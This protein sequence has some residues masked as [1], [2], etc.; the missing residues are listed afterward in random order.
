LRFQAISFLSGKKIYMPTTIT[1]HGAT[2]LIQSNDLALWIPPIESAPFSTEEEEK[3]IS[4]GWR[5][6][7]EGPLLF[8]VISRFG[9]IYALTHG[10][11]RLYYAHEGVIN[12]AKRA[13][14]ILG[15]TA[16]YEMA[17]VLAKEIKRYD[18]SREAVFLQVAQQL[19]PPDW[20]TTGL[21]N[22]CSY[23]VLDLG[24]N[25]IRLQ[26]RIRDLVSE[27]VAPATWWLVD[28][29]PTDSMIEKMVK[30]HANLSHGGSVAMTELAAM[31][32]D[33]ADV[34]MIHHKRVTEDTAPD[35]PDRL[36][37]MTIGGIPDLDHTIDV[38]STQVER[39][40]TKGLQKRNWEPDEQGRPHQPDTIDGHPFDTIIGPRPSEYLCQFPNEPIPSGLVGITSDDLWRVAKRFDDG[41]IDMMLILCAQ[42]WQP[43]Y[44][45]GA[46]TIISINQLLSYRGVQKM[47]HSEDNRRGG[48]HAPQ[49]EEARQRVED[50]SYVK[51]TA[52]FINGGSTE[53][54][55][56]SIHQRWAQSAMF[57]DSETTT[58]AYQIG[59]WASI[60]PGYHPQ[61][62]L[63]AQAVFNYDW[64]HEAW[65]KRLGYW[66]MF[67]F[68]MSVGASDIHSVEEILAET[69][70]K[71]ENDEQAHPARTRKNFEQGLDQLKKDHIIDG[72]EYVDAR[73]LPRYGWL[74][75]WL[76]FNVRIIA[77]PY[78][79]DQYRPIARRRKRHAEIAAQRTAIA[80][81]T[82]K[83]RTRKKNK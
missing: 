15:W 37:P 31:A 82:V 47:L 72:W 4:A 58:W 21:Y 43:L 71:N 16:S 28:A 52:G 63:M 62:A 74:A 68:R 69:S 66:A 78:V 56:M 44:K 17:C 2:W 12:E 8:A 59:R 73:E 64:Y 70:L 5:S 51:F 48:Y 20:G 24:D 13:P 76:T 61:S 57:R 3:L 29:I 30:Q 79:V 49:R 9:Q 25:G 67:R 55:L 1:G 19:P 32:S 23:N 46:D 41:H 65:A 34:Y 33:L 77:P 60:M 18:S 6:I 53:L 38:P 7:E 54:Y 83:Q 42:A 50:L 27:M 75:T 26:T 80:E 81:E 45:S 36:M 10:D 40:L 14:I 35:A 11:R 39:G 22:T